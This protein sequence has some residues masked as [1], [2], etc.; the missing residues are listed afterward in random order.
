M[1]KQLF[2]SVAA[3]GLA[4]LQGCNA[5]GCTD[6][7]SS[8]PLAGFYSYR[9]L[10]PITVNDISVGAVGA[11]NDSLLLDKGSANRLYM[12]FNIGEDQTTYFIRYTA[13]GM[14]NPE[15]FDTITFH[16]DRIPYFASEECGAMYSYQI[17]SVTN[18]F[19]RIDSLAI[20]RPTINNMDRESIR[21]FFNALTPDSDDQQKP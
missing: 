3:I 18:T 8:L 14:D 2:L 19:H 12:P 16:Y 9:T 21:I 1:K 6:N 5:S 7:K 11:P 10:E 13:E 20:T 15:L 4:M 17:K